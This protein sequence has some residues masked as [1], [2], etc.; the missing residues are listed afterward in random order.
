MRPRKTKDIESALKKKGFASRE[1]DHTYFTLIVNGKRSTVFTKLSHGIKEYGSPL[2]GRI[3]RQLSL[4]PKELDELLDCPMTE[5]ILVNTLRMRG[6][7]K[8]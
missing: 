3:A 1:G 4:G 2:L 8:G 6:R 7:V 5:E